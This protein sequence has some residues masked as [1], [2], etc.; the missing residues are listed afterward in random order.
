MN[1]EARVAA[2]GAIGG[3]VNAILC[4]ARIP[5]PAAQ[6]AT[7]AW[8]II[9]AGACHGALL[10][11]A[12]LV[13]AR[14]FATRGML[15]RCFLALPVAWFAGFVSW[16]PVNRSA[17]DESWADS[18]TWPF[19]Q[20]W[21]L[22][23]LGPCQYFG[24]VSGLLYLALISCRQRVPN[25]AIWVLSASASGALGS[26]WWWASAEPWYFS[27]LHGTIWGAAV[28]AGSWRWVR[29]ENELS[30]RRHS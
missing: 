28:A 30:N 19:H 22:G 12:A 13:S 2:G 18:L 4:Y 16:I 14:L 11:L 15:L 25:V 7:F 1:A 17:L 23:V 26:L 20:G 21:A 9:P 3:A 24:L 5:V 8:H 29:A 27:P 6:T 10:S